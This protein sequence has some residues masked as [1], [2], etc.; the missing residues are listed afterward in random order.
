MKVNVLKPTEIELK[1]G[2]QVELDVKYGA[3]RKVYVIRLVESLHKTYAVLSN[4]TY[5]P[6]STYGFTWRKVND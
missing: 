2:D 6:M 4:G 1:P 5:R 3:P